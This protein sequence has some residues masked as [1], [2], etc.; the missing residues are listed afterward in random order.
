[1]MFLTTLKISL[2]NVAIQGLQLPNSI[3]DLTL[4]DFDHTKTSIFQYP[5]NLQKLNLVR[6]THV[7]LK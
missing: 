3:R 4:L 2:L 7:D 1:M 6:A 5:K